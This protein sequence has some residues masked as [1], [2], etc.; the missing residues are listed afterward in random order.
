MQARVFNNVFV[1]YPK[2]HF[3]KS[4]ANSEKLKNE[5]NYYLNLPSSVTDLFPKLITYHPGYTDYTLEY[6]PFKSLAELIV[7]NKITS[8]E[9]K[10]I[11]DDLFKILDRLHAI[12]LASKE[13]TK[14]IQEFYIGKTLERLDQLSSNSYFKKLLKTPYLI[15]NNKSYDNFFKLK[16][17]FVKSIQDLSAEDSYLSVFHGDF[18]FSNILYC[19]KTKNIKLVDPRGSFGIEGIYGH[20]YYDYAKL[21]HCLHGRYDYIVNNDFELEEKEFGQFNLKSS[22]STVLHKLYQFYCQLLD[23]RG[24][25][26]TFLYFI[27]ASLFLS[28]PVLHYEDF[29][30]Q[31][32][33][34]LTGLIILNNIFRGHHENLYRH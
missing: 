2:G 8:E 19:P 6:V 20:A 34:F 5:I 16:D 28:M 26:L 21:L 7:E 17:F 4:S 33:L 24:V 1:D 30:R 29:R 11:I 18:C 15:I 9:G 3:I 10:N 25:N 27:E 13:S 14:Q 23:I 32:A 12:H 31:K 22:C